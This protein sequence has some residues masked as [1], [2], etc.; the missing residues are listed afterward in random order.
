[1]NVENYH[2]VSLQITDLIPP[3]PNSSSQRYQHEQ[4]ISVFRVVS[5]LRDLNIMQTLNSEIRI[6]PVYGN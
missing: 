6:C 3:V 1:M 2:S 4:E 5:V